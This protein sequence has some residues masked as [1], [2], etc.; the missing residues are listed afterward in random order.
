MNR[1]VK[2]INI[3]Q[4]FKHE[5]AYH[6]YLWV[7]IV[8]I[9]LIVRLDIGHLS[10]TIISRMGLSLLLL[11]IIPSYSHYFIYDK[12]LVKRKFIRYF[13][14][15]IFIIVIPSLMLQ[16][17]DIEIFG[18]KPPRFLYI[19][20]II[21]FMFLTTALKI[22]IDSYKQKVRFKEMET[23]QLKTELDLLKYQM[24][25]HFLFNALN[26]IYSIALE[27]KD[28]RIASGITTLS[29]LM[30]YVIHESKV[31]YINLSKEIEQINSYIDLQKMRFSDEDN[32]KI[33]FTIN[34]EPEKYKIAPML[35]IPFV[36]NA[37]K[38]SL[39]H[40]S[41]AHIEIKLTIVNSDLVFSVKNSKSQLNL[42]KRFNPSGIGL[43]NVKRRLDLLYPGEYNFTISNQEDFFKVFLK[44]KFKQ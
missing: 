40:E 8:S 19:Y 5:I 22:L 33:E 31:D 38:H 41:P 25:P 20:N 37:F 43:K 1:S 24:N 39:S 29:S 2:K 21:I 4:I 3:L 9:S 27:I 17:C 35:L 10:F 30:R 11:G 34:G 36:E 14:F 13:V 7:F 12:Y 32:I 26:N 15:L 16:G 28:Q 6:I 18:E 23:R 44:I 42:D